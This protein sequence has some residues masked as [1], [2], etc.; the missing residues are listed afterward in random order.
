MIPKYFLS[1]CRSVNNF[2]KWTVENIFII[3]IKKKYKNI[4]I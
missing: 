4:H 3:K 1:D 2:I